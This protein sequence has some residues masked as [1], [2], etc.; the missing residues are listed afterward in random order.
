RYEILCAEVKD[1]ECPKGDL[2]LRRFV[3]QTS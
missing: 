3:L 2:F 1:L